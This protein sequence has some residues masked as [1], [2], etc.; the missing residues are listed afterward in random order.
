VRFLVG[1]IGLRFDRPLVGE[2]GVSS[3]SPQEGK[4]VTA[5]IEQAMQPEVAARVFRRR[6]GGARRQHDS[7]HRLWRRTRHSDAIRLQI[8]D[9]FE[10]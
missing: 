5:A 2:S 6:I 9:R 3:D 8:L 1:W 4:T 7:G 10:R